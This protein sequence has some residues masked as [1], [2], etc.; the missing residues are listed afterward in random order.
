[1]P[2]TGVVR[3]AQALHYVFDEGA[4]PGEMIIRP[5]SAVAVELDAV[6]GAGR[7]LPGRTREHEVLTHRVQPEVAEDAELPAYVPDE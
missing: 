4:N 2:V 7:Q 1:M 6:P 5:G 3:F